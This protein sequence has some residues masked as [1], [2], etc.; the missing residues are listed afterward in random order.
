MKFRF[1]PDADAEFLAAI[2]WYEDR[3]VGLGADF[4]VEIQAGIQR[5]VAMPEAWPRMGGD[6]RRVLIRRFP[7]GVVYALR[8]EGLLVLAVMHLRRS[9][10]YWRER[11]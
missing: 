8:E 6:V 3:A 5:A 9:P 1:H 10:G 4:A 2:D 7:Y 11:E